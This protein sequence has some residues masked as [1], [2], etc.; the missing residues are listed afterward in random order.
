MT[1]GRLV[2][3]RL[4]APAPD[5][6]AVYRR[7]ARIADLLVISLWLSSAVAVGLFLVAGGTARFGAIP[8]A[9]TSVGIMTGLVGTNLVLAML[10]LAARVPFVDHAIGH[11]RAIA[12]HRA[13]GKPA[14]LLLLGHG[15]I[16]LVGYG[17]SSGVNPI[18]EVAPLLAIPDMPLAIVGIALLAVVVVSSLAALRRRFSYETWHL[19]HLAS[20]LA[21]LVSIPHQLS[22]GSVFSP[23]SFERAYWVVLYLLAFGAIFTHRFLEPLLSSIRHNLRVDRMVVEA[24][25]V[26]SIHLRGRRLRSLHSSG[27][28]FFVWRFWTPGTW[29]HSHPISLSSM[30]TDTT[31]RITVRD[32]GEGSRSISAV[33]PGTRVWFEGPYGVFTDAGRTA[34]KL[35]IVVAG[36]G[37]T[38]VRALV[39]DSV[40]R[41]G[42]ASMLLRA[43]TPDD[44][45]LWGEVEDLARR[46]GIAVTTMV[47]RRSSGESGWMTQHAADDGVTLLTVFPDLAES[48]LYL[49]GPTAWLALVEADA[50]AAGVPEHRIHAERFDW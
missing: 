1:V 8:D 2:D 47:G 4:S 34:K 12:A 17:L 9:V 41:P 24:P 48:D 28:Q 29:W 5:H 26:V 10:L 14:F 22:I 15:V 19:I 32:L 27:G 7:R 45:F 42:E 13:L 11:D 49:C 20:Y 37:I 33:R 40:L 6:L 39:Q 50:R 18:A 3:S 44:T 35:A 38:P 25:G 43:S 16:L 30:A 46:K 21:V 36:I 23:L 31:M